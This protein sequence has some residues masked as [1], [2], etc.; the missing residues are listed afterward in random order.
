[1]GLAPRFV[2]AALILIGCGDS[3]LLT[4]G[5]NPPDPQ[6][7]E[8]PRY[9]LVRQ[10]DELSLEDSKNDNPTL[11]ADLRNIY[12]TTTR[13]DDSGTD[14]WFSSRASAA[15]RFDPPQ[16]F[17]LVNTD[18]DEASPAI[19]LDGLE[20]FYGSDDDAG[21]GE[22]DIWSV[23]RPTRDA[24][25]SEPAPV[26]G[27]N[28]AEDDIPRPPGYGGRLMPLGSRA[29]GTGY[30]ATYLA[31]RSD[32]SGDFGTPVLVRELLQEDHSTIDAFL[33]EDGLSL[34][35]NLTPDSG[36]TKGDLYMAVRT[37]VTQPFGD[38]EPIAELNSP[39]DERD[40]WLSPDGRI[41][42]FSSDRGGSLN[43]YEAAISDL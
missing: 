20:L 39:N 35:F 15:D 17:T 9:T 14:V 1:M 42:F 4:L 43:I 32:A 36:E 12:F 19:S 10:V 23:R 25:W 21:M 28:T 24:A 3:R 41:L 7:N 2:L 6:A 5:R 37:N 22:L 31:A 16:P 13:G 33:S 29:M 30:Y 38:A 40:P 26:P 27:L 11:T 18:E 8:R 34:Y